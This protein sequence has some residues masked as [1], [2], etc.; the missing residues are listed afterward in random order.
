MHLSYSANISKANLFHKAATSVFKRSSQVDTHGYE[1]F[2]QYRSLEDSFTPLADIWFATNLE[3]HEPEFLSPARFREIAEQWNDSGL[4]IILRKYRSGV[5]ALQLSNQAKNADGLA[6]LNW[7][8]KMQC[9]PQDAN[10][11]WNRINGG[12]T[13][14][15][16]AEQFDWSLSF[17]LEELE[18]FEEK[19]DLCRD[20]NEG[21]IRF[22]R[23]KLLVPA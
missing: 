8:E 18:S 19:G 2:L 9:D 23:N 11:N 15:E 16:I 20:T 6:L 4:P 21:E 12:V 1:R 13:V 7:L 10:E 17:A 5:L 22:W 14:V 3:V